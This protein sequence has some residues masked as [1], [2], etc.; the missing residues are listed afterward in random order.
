[1]EQR[2]KNIVYVG[3]GMAVLILI[4]LAAQKKPAAPSYIAGS[5]APVPGNLQPVTLRDAP[6]PNFALPSADDF[7]DLL[8]G[9]NKRCCNSCSDGNAI[10]TLKQP[11]VYASA[12][13][14]PQATLASY[15]LTGAERKAIADGNAEIVLDDISSRGFSVRSLL[16]PLKFRDAYSVLPVATGGDLFNVATE[17]NPAGDVAVTAARGGI[18]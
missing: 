10:N 8:A 15:S 7:S 6:R 4:V 5:A 9:M 12:I 18:H 16:D 14:P 1:M 2:Y 11:V 3:G 13:M 17:I